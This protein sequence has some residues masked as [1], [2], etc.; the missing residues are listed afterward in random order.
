MSSP[1]LTRI[2]ITDVGST[3]TKAILSDKNSDNDMEFLS[4]ME[5]V[6]I[7][8]SRKRLVRKSGL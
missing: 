7:F 5:S 1:E 2:C 8:N 3:T 4:D 6:G